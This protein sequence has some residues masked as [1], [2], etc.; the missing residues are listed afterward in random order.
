MQGIIKLVLTFTLNGIQ[1]S[2]V[3]LGFLLFLPILLLVKVLV[4]FLFHV[5]SEGQL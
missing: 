3:H 5:V 2:Q 1:R 4:G